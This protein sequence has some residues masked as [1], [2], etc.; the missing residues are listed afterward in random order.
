MN[1]FTKRAITGMF[2]VAAIILLIIL[3]QYS[4]YFLLLIINSLCTY[5]FLKIT[6][7]SDFL[8]NW[9]IINI[10]FLIIIFFQIEI[11]VFFILPLVFAY[12]AIENIFKE[13]QNW[14][15]LAYLGVSMLY[16][17]FPLILLNKVTNYFNE[18]NSLIAL[19]FIVLIWCSDTF[20][21]LVGKSF[22]KTPLFP[23]IS[24]KK[25]KEGFWGALILTSISAYF[26]GIW[27]NVEPIFNVLIGLVTV[28]TGSLG[29]IVESGL[30]RQNN[31]KDSGSILPGHGG[32]LDRFDALLISLPFTT[33][34]F[35]ILNEFFS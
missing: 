20:A 27:F 24:P 21:Y 11:D 13:N 25:T 19:N 31:L 9:I 32:F 17:T 18:F 3:H 34:T 35:Y 15:Q 16:I 2:F 29:D 10:A 6:L 14:N 33:F 8:K 5:E 4:F 1:N 23:K 26:L 28:I 22:G 12:F 7:K 30:K